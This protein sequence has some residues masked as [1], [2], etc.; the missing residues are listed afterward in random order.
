MHMKQGGDTHLP[1]VILSHVM[2]LCKLMIKPF[3]FLFS[4][5]FYRCTMACCVNLSFVEVKK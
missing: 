2:L 5:K 4:L 1:V 3:G